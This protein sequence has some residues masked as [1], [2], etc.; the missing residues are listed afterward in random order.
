MKYTHTQTNIP[1]ENEYPKIVRDEI[2]RIIKD[3]DGIDADVF[4]VK[5]KDEHLEYLKK[6]VVEEASELRDANNTEHI[7]E[8]MAD[9]LE[10]IDAMCAVMNIDKKDVLRIQ[11]EKR[12]KRG[13]FNKGIVM[14]K[15]A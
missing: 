15:K 7:V 11:D 5:D 8:E 13:G 3:N 4:L 1:E 9:V 2:P 12:Q 14:N 6:K 10:V